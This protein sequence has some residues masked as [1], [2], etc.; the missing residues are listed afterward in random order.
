LY[1]PG[2]PLLSIS[3]KKKG[4]SGRALCWPLQH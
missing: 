4:A 2:H 1:K 3:P